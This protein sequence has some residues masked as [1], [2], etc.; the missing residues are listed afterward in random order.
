MHKSTFKLEYTLPKC[1]SMYSDESILVGNTA[2]TFS[3]IYMTLTTIPIIAKISFTELNLNRYHELIANHLRYLNHSH[4]EDNDTND[5]RI[6]WRRREQKDEKEGKQ[7]DCQVS[8]RRWK[9]RKEK[10]KKQT[11]MENGKQERET[12]TDKR[13]RGGSFRLERMN[14]PYRD[15][16]RIEIFS[17][18]S[19]RA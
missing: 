13:E 11:E 4:L 17:L 9:K 16:F 10:K 2:C 5:A 3:I 6:S 12:A 7:G 15:N 8:N 18:S 19:N 1:C 14:S